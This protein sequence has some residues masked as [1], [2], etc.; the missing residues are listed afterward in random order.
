M[1]TTSDQPVLESTNAE[2]QDATPIQ[3]PTDV[4]K[5]P[6]GDLNIVDWDSPD[7]PAD[8]MSFSGSIKS[9]NV[10]IVR[11]LT[12][13]TPLASSM[14][15]PG[16]PQIMA[17][18]KST[19]TLLAGFV[20]SV[21]V[22]GFAL[23][24][25]LLAPASELY[26]RAI[27]YHICNIGFIVFTV[28]C[29]VSTDLGM[30]IAFRFFQGCFGSAPVTN[31]GGTIADLI[32]QEKRG[33]VIAIYALGPILGP[34][35]G[36]V[37]GGY[38]VAARGWRWVF[39]VLTMIGGF[40]TVISAFFLRETYTTV[41]L[42]RKTA[43]LINETG[44]TSLRS[45]RDNGLT[46]KQLFIRAITRPTKILIMSPIVST[47]SIYVGVVY[48]YQYLMFATFTFVFEEQY[49]FSTKS[50]DLTYSGIGVGSLLG[51]LAIGAVSDRILKAKSKPTP[52][53]PSGTM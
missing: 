35:I 8:P 28:A 53:S 43:R 42:H 30:L 29:A 46:V 31:G 39:W 10:G 15:A 16:V 19:N 47:C 11:G 4:E 48:G 25:L 32:V 13:I 40:F 3:T 45:K 6:V 24:P 44:N 18:F 34:V 21:Y 38:L 50:S 20:V 26:G 49:G 27:I 5:F 14:F 2:K 33:G 9:I 51:L 52:E 1:A 36:P 22:L 12:F 41:L 23:G 37:A 17:D 7:D